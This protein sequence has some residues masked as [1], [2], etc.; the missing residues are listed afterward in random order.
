MGGV[1]R[2]EVKKPSGAQLTTDDQDELGHRL[3][4]CLAKRRAHGLL[5]LLQSL[6]ILPLFLTLLFLDSEQKAQT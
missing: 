5:G 1:S 2:N 3:H 4:D 6:F